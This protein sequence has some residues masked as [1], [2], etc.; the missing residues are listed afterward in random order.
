MVRLVQGPALRRSVLARSALLGPAFVA[1]I[2]YV[3]PGNVAANVT[4]GARYGFLLV[5]VLVVAGVIAM[6]VQYQSAK[7]GVV[8]GRSVP[9]LVGERLGRGARIGY[10]LQ[11]EVVAAATDLAEVIGG[12]IALNLLFGL[13]L[14]VGGVIIAVVSLIILA[15]ASRRGQRSFELVVGGFLVVIVVGFLAG[16]VVNAPSPS[17]VAGGLIPRLHGRESVLLAAGMFGATVMPHVVYLH[18]T[19]VID[20][21]G[22]GHSAPVVRKLLG[23]TRVDVIVALG[24]AG[25][26]NIALL[27]LAAQNLRHVPGTD[28]IDGAYHAVRHSLGPLIAVLFAAGLLASSLA[29]TAVGSY[30]GAAIMQGMLHIRV[31]MIIRRLVVVTPAL[32]VLGVGVEPTWALVV[33]QVVLSFGI[34]FA[35]IALAR[36][37]SDRT[38]MGEFTDRPLLRWASVVSTIVIVALNVALIVLAF[39]G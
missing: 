5:W 36:L 22:S 23:A 30:A 6:L 14:V 27:V 19:L 2:A 13:P 35:I 16:L 33:S 7:L 28:T 12:A 1:A 29:S 9:E 11:A 3:D 17:D 32:I 31:P 10:W 25:L 39:T 4:A 21:H 26:V 37:T 20:R 38:L 24:I 18:S 8:T 34:P 15:I